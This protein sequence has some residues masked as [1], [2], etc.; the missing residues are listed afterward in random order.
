MPRPSSA[1]VARA[2]I[3]V[4]EGISGELRN[5]PGVPVRPPARKH[6][7]GAS[8]ADVLRLSHRP[9]ESMRRASIRNLAESGLAGSEGATEAARRRSAAI[10]AGRRSNCRAEQP[11]LGRL[12]WKKAPPFERGLRCGK[13][14]SLKLVAVRTLSALSPKGGRV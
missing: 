2:S 6:A 9:K 8:P 13:L 7:H 5:R 14:I 1:D 3:H 11:A 12:L 10:C 4:V